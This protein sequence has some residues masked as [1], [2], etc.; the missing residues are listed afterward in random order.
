MSTHQ[1]T[2]TKNTY[3]SPAPFSSPAT[4]KLQS[5]VA[6][7]SDPSLPYSYAQKRE[8]T[9]NSYNNPLGA[10]TSAATRDAAGRVANDRQS[11]DESAAIQ[12][13]N[14]K[15]QQAEFARQLGVVGATQPFQTGGTSVQSQSI[16]PGLITA[17][18]GVGSSALTKGAT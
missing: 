1:K 16:I 13:S 17:A 5:L 6:Q 9:L 7:G 3:G 2:E 8:D 4:D 12:N 18:A 10:Y 14:Y 11:M 15:E